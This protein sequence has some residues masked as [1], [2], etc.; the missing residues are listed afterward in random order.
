MKTIYKRPLAITLLAST[1]IL[2]AACDGLPFGNQ[3]PDGTVLETWE[4]K[5]LDKVDRHAEMDN[6]P[7]PTPKHSQPCMKRKPNLL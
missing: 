1:S 4:F 6:E 7:Q 5:N 2:L 3:E